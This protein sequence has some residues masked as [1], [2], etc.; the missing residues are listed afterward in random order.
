M[1]TYM[2]AVACEDRIRALH[3]HWDLGE[4]PFEKETRGRGSIT[5]RMAI[6]GRPKRPAINCTRG[7]SGALVKTEQR[8]S[9][10]L[11]SLTPSRR[12]PDR[13][14]NERFGFP[15]QGEATIDS[16]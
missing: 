14:A 15:K 7:L 10:E 2:S 12:Y 11:M 5:A 8:P 4:W 16:C 6:W 1:T 9:Q 13:N 3:Y